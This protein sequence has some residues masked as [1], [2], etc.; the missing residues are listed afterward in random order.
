MKFSAIT[1]YVRM[2]PSK[3]RDLARSI[4]GKSAE[5]A[6]QI[7]DHTTRKAAVQLGKTLKSAIANAENNAGL[8]VDELYVHTAVVNEGP[9]LKRIKPKA[10]GMYGPVH[11]KTSHIEVTLTDEKPSGR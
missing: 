4:Q 8:N 6:L 3:V 1:K 10:R 11:K 9:T 5:E 7:T 2:S